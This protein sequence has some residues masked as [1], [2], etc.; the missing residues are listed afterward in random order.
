MVDEGKERLNR[1]RE[2]NKGMHRRRNVDEKS[3]VAFLQY[4]KKNLNAPRP[5][6]LVVVVVSHIQRIGCQP[7]KNYLRLR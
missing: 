2:K 7:E 5:S 1:S 4:L 6:E 3:C